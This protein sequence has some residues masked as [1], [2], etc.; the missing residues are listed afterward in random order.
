MKKFLA[1][2]MALLMM[3]G[4]AIAEEG[5]DIAEKAVEVLK[6]YWTDTY[7]EFNTGSYLEIKNTRVITIADEPTGTDEFTTD[8]AQ[9]QFGDVETIVEFVLFTDYFGTAPYVFNANVNDHV[10]F[11]EDGSVEVMNNPFN[12]YRAR[13]YSMDFSGIIEDVEDLQDAHNGAWLLLVE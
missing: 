8:A 7:V 13:T 2:L 3:M 1:I 11:Y 6:D 10:V 12:H 9:K 5:V 4:T